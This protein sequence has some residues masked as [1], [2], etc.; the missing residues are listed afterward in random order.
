MKKLLIAAMIAVTLTGCAGLST[1]EQRI[2]SG[3]II[4]GAAGNLLGGGAFGTLGGAAI[5]GLIGNEMDRNAQQP[6][7][8]N[9]HYSDQPQYR[10]DRNGHRY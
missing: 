6:Q 10:Y 1:R 8:D 4:G 5:G 3:A 7:H 9:R 2:G